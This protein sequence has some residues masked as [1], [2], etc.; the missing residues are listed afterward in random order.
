MKRYYD[1]LDFPCQFRFCFV[2]LGGEKDREMKGGGRGSGE[3][4]SW[5][6]DLGG[7]EGGEREKWGNL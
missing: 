7:W 3:A 1:R 5:M 6:L 2:G 4:E